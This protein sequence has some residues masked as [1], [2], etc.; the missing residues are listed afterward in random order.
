MEES[1]SQASKIDESSIVEKLREKIT[2]LKKDFE[3]FLESSNTLTMLFN[4]CLCLQ[5]FNLFILWTMA[6]KKIE[7]C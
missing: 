4:I 7:K 2:Y 6:L 1:L 3:K 5:I